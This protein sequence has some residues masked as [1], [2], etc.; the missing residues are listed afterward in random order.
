MQTNAA[1]KSQVKKAK[2]NENF[3]DKK[4]QADWEFVLTIPEARRVIWGILGQCHMFETTFTGNSQGMFMEGE[5][6]VGLSIW[7]KIVAAKP[8][9]IFSMMKDSQRRELNND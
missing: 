4:D 8:D 7:A 1:D 6:N 5:R 3:I 9:A 2:L